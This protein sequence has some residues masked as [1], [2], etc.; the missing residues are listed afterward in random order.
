MTSSTI[1][2]LSILAFISISILLLNCASAKLG[3][4]SSPDAG[5]I[6]FKQDETA[7]HDWGTVL[8]KV[9][10]LKV[11]GSYPDLSVIMRGPKSFSNSSGPL[12]VL[13]GVVIGRSFRELATI[14]DPSSVKKIRVLNGPEA[15]KY[16][17]RGGFGV[18]EVVL[19][20]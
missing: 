16:G 9:P 15:A 19:K 13:D 10:G 7:P 5:E 12:Y 2:R 6:N 1:N 8:R 17:M 20:D 11:S 4:D 3:T 18:I 14:A